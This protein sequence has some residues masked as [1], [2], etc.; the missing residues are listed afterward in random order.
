[1]SHPECQ[2]EDPEFDEWCDKIIDT[3]EKIKAEWK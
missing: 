1:M 2:K 3:L